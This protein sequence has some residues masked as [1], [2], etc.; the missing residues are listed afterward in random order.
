MKYL[1]P[2]F[3][4]IVI[5]FFLIIIL[6]FVTSSIF[7]DLVTTSY[8]NINLPN[9][10]EFFNKSTPPAGETIYLYIGFI[11]KN[12]ISNFMASVIPIPQ[13]LLKIHNPATEDIT[14]YLLLGFID[15]FYKHQHQQISSDKLQEIIDNIKPRK[16]GKYYFRNFRSPNNQ[17]S[18]YVMCNKDSHILYAFL[19]YIQ[20]KDPAFINKSSMELENS[21]KTLVIKD[22]NNIDT[23]QSDLS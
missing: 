3:F 10:M 14:K 20:S 5:K 18:F 22:Q 21:L 2:N 7:A 13:K 9:T 6:F 11:D 15:S 12:N 23:S 8:F 16:I 1:I 17:Y 19:S 4:S